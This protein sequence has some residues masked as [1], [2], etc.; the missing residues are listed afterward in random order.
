MSKSSPTAPL[1]QTALD[2]NAITQRDSA[3]PGLTNGTR[4]SHGT[5]CA[6]IVAMEKSNGVCGVGVAYNSRITGIIYFF[7]TVLF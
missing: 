2:Y 1:Q 4:D 7:F 5:S 3:F 6:G